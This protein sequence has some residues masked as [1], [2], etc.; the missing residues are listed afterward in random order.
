MSM[1]GLLEEISRHHFPNSPASPSR[2]EEFEHRA[3][4]RLDADLRAFYLHCDGARLFKRDDEIYRI[5]PLSEIVRARVAIL[6]R[7]SDDHGPASWYVV[8]DTGDTDYVALDTSTT[9]NGRYPLLDCFHETFMEP[10]GNRRIAHSFS[11]FL[12]RA[13]HSG[14]CLYWLKR[15]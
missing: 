5:L 13:L 4:W 10:E 7:D 2:I 12:E 14:G 15:A 11:D 3:G 1:D 6:G 9:E 8:C